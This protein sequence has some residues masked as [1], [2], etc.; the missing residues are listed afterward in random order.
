MDRRFQHIPHHGP[1]E[2]SV[3]RMFFAF[4][5]AV[6][7]TGVLIISWLFLAD[8]DLLFSPATIRDAEAPPSLSTY[9]FDSA[10]L[11]APTRLV[12][13][14]NRRTLG[15]VT[16]L[17]LLLPWPY[18][19]G[20]IPKLPETA[21]EFNDWLMLTF[22][23]GVKNELTP[24]ERYGEIYPV[25]FDGEPELVSGNLLR[26]RFRKG[27]PYGDLTL[28]V[29]NSGGNHV[30]HRCDLKPSV[31][32]PILCERTIKLTSDIQL[33]IRF[34]RQHLENWARIERNVRL[35]MANMFRALQQ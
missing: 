19:A 31:L 7:V 32:G 1:Q 15:S 27:S 28:Y 5:G 34:A 33:R 10:E 17:D 14:V 22:E 3:G 11:T 26:Y 4:L 25:Y 23:S 30:V 18:Q 21:A 8:R 13:R 20:T 12:T 2:R 24:I 6:F 35:A 29:A 9:S 16:K